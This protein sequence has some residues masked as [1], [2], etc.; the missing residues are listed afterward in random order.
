MIDLGT[1]EFKIDADRHKIAANVSPILG[2]LG[3]LRPQMDRMSPAGG[4]TS[5]LPA[6]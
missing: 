5:L 2:L 3:T 4:L 1:V 6:H